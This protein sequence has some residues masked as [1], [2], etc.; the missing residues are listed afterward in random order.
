MKFNCIKTRIIFAI[1]NYTRK[2]D[3]KV[4]YKK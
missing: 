4:T 2:N 1:Y 3:N